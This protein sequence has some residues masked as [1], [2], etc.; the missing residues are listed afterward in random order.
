M[1]TAAGAALPL[2]LVACSACSTLPVTPVEH[3]Q[4]RDLGE[5]EGEDLDRAVFRVLVEGQGFG[6]TRRT[7]QFASVYY[8]TEWKERE[9]L[10]P[11]EAR[12]VSEAR[13]RFLL[14][15]RRTSGGRYRTTVEAES[16]VRTDSLPEWHSVPVT[17][18][19][20]EWVDSVVASLRAAMARDG[21]ELGRG[22]PGDSPRRALRSPSPTTEDS[23]R[24]EETRR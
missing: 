8:E 15:G 10:A 23:N 6:L 22:E 24:F 1:R 21:R 5:V 7:R 4:F 18:A 13:S 12:R 11:E 16:Q 17:P 20:G 9:P 2:V 19:F 14:R 3:A